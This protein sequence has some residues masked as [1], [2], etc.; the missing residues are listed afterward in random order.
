MAASTRTNARKVV[1]VVT[2]KFSF[3]LKPLA[4]IGE[5]TF[6]WSTGLWKLVGNGRLWT[7][8]K[9]FKVVNDPIAGFST[10]KVKSGYIRGYMK[11]GDSFLFST[12]K[13][14]T[15]KVYEG[16]TFIVGAYPSVY[17][18]WFYENQVN[19]LGYFGYCEDTEEVLLF[20]STTGANY[21]DVFELVPADIKAFQEQATQYPSYSVDVGRVVGGGGDD[22]LRAQ[23]AGKA[24]RDAVTAKV[25]DNDL[26]EYAPVRE[27][28]MDSESL[29][30]EAR[31]SFAKA[32]DP[33][34]SAEVPVVVLTAKELAT[35]MRSRKAVERGFF[36]SFDLQGKIPD[37]LE[38][39]RKKMRNESGGLKLP[40]PYVAPQPKPF[41]M[42]LPKMGKVG[43][44]S[45]VS[46][47]E[48]DDL[49]VL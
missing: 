45:S 49:V 34:A 33:T 10:N 39:S 3:P 44:D 17:P 15:L 43:R 23:R 32:V 29:V 35:V 19:V 18:V 9:D 42:A 2:E 36:G 38:E 26:G 25:V 41:V 31:K 47:T 30:S 7:V 20:T 27:P 8:G 40:L 1:P 16:R 4:E 28:G 6:L 11:S 14:V 12:S 24:L 37:P 5:P 46:K 48:D 13:A 22:K 21:P